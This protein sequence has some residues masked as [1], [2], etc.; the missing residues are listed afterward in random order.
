MWLHLDE[1]P[2]LRTDRRSMF[3]GVSIF[4]SVSTGGWRISVAIEFRRAGLEYIIWWPR[5]ISDKALPPD[6]LKDRLQPKMDDAS[7]SDS[8]A[9]KASCSSQICGH[10][11][12]DFLFDNIG[13]KSCA[14]SMSSKPSEFPAT[15]GTVSSKCCHREPHS[16]FTFS[17]MQSLLLSDSAT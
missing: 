10:P 7:S 15:D 1:A 12:G 13:W 8:E 17:S 16:R 5:S 3:A 2:F 11:S 9:S 14:L 6:W 4:G